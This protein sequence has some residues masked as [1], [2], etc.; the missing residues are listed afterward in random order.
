MVALLFFASVIAPPPPAAPVEPDPD[1][2]PADTGAQEPAEPADTGAEDAAE[3]ESG[4]VAA[5]TAAATTSDPGG[6]SL[7]LVL[8][9]IGLLVLVIGA[10]ILF[11]PRLFSGGTTIRDDE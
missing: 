10:L 2:D 5:A 11:G 3:A 8:I 6:F 7:P 9:L 1:P 4:E